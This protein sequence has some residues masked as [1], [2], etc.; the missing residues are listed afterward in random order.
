MDY[1]ITVC[2]SALSNCRIPQSY[3]NHKEDE[4]MNSLNL[5]EAQ[6]LLT[7]KTRTLTLMN[8]LVGNFSDKYLNASS[9]DHIEGYWAVSILED[10][11]DEAGAEGYRKL[12]AKLMQTLKEE[13]KL[14]EES[15]NVLKVLGMTTFD[16]QSLL[17]NLTTLLI[18]HGKIPSLHSGKA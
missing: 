6:S 2:L 16:E 3:L 10:N 14:I 5:Q 11:G 4:E 9:E 12:H 7:Q 18:A 17:N 8:N 15:R 1:K 13:A